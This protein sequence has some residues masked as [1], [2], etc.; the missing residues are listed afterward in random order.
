MRVRE[1]T[2]DWSTHGRFGRK[3]CARNAFAVFNCSRRL[4]A[5]NVRLTFLTHVDRSGVRAMPVSHIDIICD[6]LHQPQ[7]S[8]IVVALPTVHDGIPGIC[9]ATPYMHARMHATSAPSPVSRGGLAAAR[10]VIAAG[11]DPLGRC[12]KR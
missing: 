6:A 12:A 8:V 7:T 2:E 4:R 5:P 9:T 1:H 10:W 11:G 3:I